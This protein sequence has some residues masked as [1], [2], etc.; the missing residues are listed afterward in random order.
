[1]RNSSS[2]TDLVTSGEVFEGEV[3]TTKEVG[4]DRESDFRKYREDVRRVRKE[5]LLVRV[6]RSQEGCIPI[7][8]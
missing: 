2:I 8:D 3:L 5:G 6:S 4:Q 7:R 1:M